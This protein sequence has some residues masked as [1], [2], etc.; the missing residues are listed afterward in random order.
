MI[1]FKQRINNLVKNPNFRRAVIIYTSSL[2]I[3]V[4]GAL[5][6]GNAGWYLLTCA[7][8][9][10]S[11]VAAALLSN[12]HKKPVTFKSVLS[13][14]V[15]TGIFTGVSIVFGIPLDAVFLGM[16]LSFVGSFAGLQFCRWEARATAAESNVQQ[17]N[18]RETINN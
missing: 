2:V 17:E 13:T 12:G 15:M 11:G 8:G 3:G 14:F 16:F 6:L 4:V 9:F 10:C 1:T 18:G 7:P 5:T